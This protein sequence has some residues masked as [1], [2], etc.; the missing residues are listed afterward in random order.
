[1][2]MLIFYIQI[3][4]S[5][6]RRD[7]MVVGFTLIKLKKQIFCGSDELYS[8]P[9]ANTNILFKILMACSGSR[10]TRML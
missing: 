3:M 4:R 10:M 2:S 8:H 7:C 5:R 9:I 1:M 6:R